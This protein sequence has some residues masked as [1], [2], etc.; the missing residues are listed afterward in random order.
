MSNETTKSV[1]A[2]AVV[3]VLKTAAPA[4]QAIPAEAIEAAV[5][6]ALAKMATK[7]K[8]DAK[9][10]EPDWSKLT[11]AEAMSAAVYIPVIEHDIPDYMNMKLKDAEY[12]CV[13][14][15]KDQRR[16]GQL[17]AEGYEFL[18]KE[19][20]HPD[21]KLPLLF[22]GEGNYTY[23]DVVCMR[24]HKRIV[25]GKRKKALQISLNQLANRNRPPRVKIEGTFD[26]APG[27][28]PEVGSFYETI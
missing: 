17:Q 3:D 8:E 26:L 18:R 10:K 1:N 15:A 23:A 13:W 27:S 21:F 6:E 24:V 11:E 2:T 9:P 16:I 5:N 14:A 20:I 19:H 22:D 28:T 12:M 25:Y 4:V 7:R